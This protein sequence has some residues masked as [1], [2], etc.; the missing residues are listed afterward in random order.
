[1]NCIPEELSTRVVIGQLGHDFVAYFSTRSKFS[2]VIVEDH[3]DL[4]LYGG[5][6]PNPFFRGIA[7]DH[8]IRLTNGA[9]CEVELVKN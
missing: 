8:V 2:G 4:P 5:P 9:S 3:V 1:M 7:T 6:Q